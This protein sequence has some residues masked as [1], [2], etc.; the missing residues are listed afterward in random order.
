MT[1]DVPLTTEAGK[2]D[3]TDRAAQMKHQAHSHL[4]LMRFVTRSPR[5]HQHDHKS[6]KRDFSRDREKEIY[7]EIGTQRQRDRDV[8]T[9]IEIEKRERQNRTNGNR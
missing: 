8:E 1:V 7:M 5:N 3:I 9:Q 2:A 6:P 4:S